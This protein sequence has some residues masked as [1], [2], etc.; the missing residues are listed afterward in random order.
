[1]NL[2]TDIL[3]KILPTIKNS[4]Q[5]HS[6]QNAI[7]IGFPTMKQEEW[8]YTYYNKILQQGFSF[9]TAEHTQTSSIT[10][11]FIDANATS[12]NRIVF[13]NGIFHNEFSSLVNH[14]KINFWNSNN[15]TE[16]N[17]AE[18]L[19]EINNAL[20]TDGIF[21]EIGDHVI[22]DEPIEIFYLS[23]NNQA[24]INLKNKIIVGKNA[25]VKFAEYAINTQQSATY[26]NIVTSINVAENANVEFYK[27]QDG[28]A[29]FYST[30]NTFV[31]QAAKSVCNITTLSL[32]GEII[33][34]VLQ[35]DIN[36]ERAAAHMNGLYLLQQNEHVDNR[37]LVNHNVANCE[38]FEL[39]KGILGGTSTGVFNGKI[40]VKQAAQKTNAFQSNRN[41]MLSNDANIYTKPQLEIFADDVKCSHGATSSQIE[42]SELFYLQARGIG[43]TTARGLLVFAFG[44][45]IVEMIKP[46]ALKIRMEKRIAELLNIEF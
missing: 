10:K 20:S 13:I 27:I 8:K 18:F 39:Y 24:I 46:E 29:G 11:E 33:R 37:T 40:V 3:E 31:H 35:F 6:L 32:S 25:Q 38:S 28:G 5:Q 34:N 2:D 45:E 19:V 21:L 14:P 22:V 17:T 41:L 16:S 30:D 7:N 26:N 36:G 43:K 4:H 44:E 1:M 9:K 42:D 15:A 12:S 23:D